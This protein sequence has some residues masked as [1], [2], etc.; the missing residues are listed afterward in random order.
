MAFSQFNSLFVCFPH[1][2]FQQFH[3]NAIIP[4][5]NRDINSAQRCSCRQVDESIMQHK[6]N[7]TNRVRTWNSL[8]CS[9][10]RAHRKHSPNTALGPLRQSALK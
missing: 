9:S 5:N 3:Y 6:C 8:R 10:E 4:A 7:Q 1:T 2:H